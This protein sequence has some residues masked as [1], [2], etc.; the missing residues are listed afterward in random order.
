MR[1]DLMRFSQHIVGKTLL[2]LI[3]LLLWA[4]SAFA[5]QMQGFVYEDPKL[6]QKDATVRLA[7]PVSVDNE[8]VL[9]G[10][11][12]DGAT[13]ELLIDI[14][15]E[16]KRS[17]WFNETINETQHS[18]VL[19]HDPLTRVFRVFDSKGEVLSEHKNIRIV[20]R[21]TL[22]EMDLPVISRTLLEQG[23][24][25]FVIITLRL[26]HV[27]LPPWLDK[28]L[29]FWSRDLIDPETIKLDYRLEDASISR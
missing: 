10:T 4:V 7:M 25:Y 8:D 6:Y 19:K 18:F 3:L 27:E 15:V 12:R 29:V 9:R 24:E 17:L 11:L 26:Q 20:L 23:E 28:T 5:A 21:N 14:K 22:K 13:V 2:P 16:R 1:Q